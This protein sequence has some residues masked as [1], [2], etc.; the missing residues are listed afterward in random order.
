MK[1]AIAGA[2][3]TGA[4]LYRMLK[5]RGE[6]AELFDRP[7]IPR[8]GLTPCAWGTSG[9]FL[10]LV[11]EA[12]LDAER[13]VL[14]HIDHVWMDDVK[15]RAQLLTFDKPRLVRDLL[16]GAE[17]KLEPLRPEDF[18]RTIDATGVARALLPSP[19]VDLVMD[20]RQYLVETDEPL[21]NRIQLGG[22]GYAWCFP[23]GAR[24]YHIGCGSF[25]RNPGE[26]LRRLGWLEDRSGR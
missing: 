18:E 19:G 10:R 16:A 2:G 17:P 26:R 24:R 23:L 20:C 12:G 14:K 22:I 6:A 21:E 25:L 15:I 13:Y 11:K 1:L 3:L 8:C 5:N 4:Y 9:E 7:A